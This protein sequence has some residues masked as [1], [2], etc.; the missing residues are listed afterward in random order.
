MHTT[1]GPKQVKTMEI[2]AGE[3]GSRP[4]E[5]RRHLQLWKCFG[6][7]YYIVIVLVRNISCQIAPDFEGSRARGFVHRSL[8]L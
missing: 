6:R 3:Q 2:Q 4:E 7:L 1:M 5:L 8:D